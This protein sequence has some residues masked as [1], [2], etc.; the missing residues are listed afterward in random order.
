LI[1][2]CLNVYP[3]DVLKRGGY[4]AIDPEAGEDITRILMA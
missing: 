2:E 3:F 1:D 4:V